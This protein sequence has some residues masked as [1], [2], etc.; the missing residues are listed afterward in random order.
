MALDLR[1]DSCEFDSRPLRCRV[2]TLGKLFIPTCLCY[3]TVEIGTGQRA[4]TP[5]AGKATVGLISHWPS[6][7][8]VSGLSIYGHKGYETE[9]R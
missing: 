6:V 3:Q 5:T 2:T 7:T 4:V 9:M 8:D 1:L